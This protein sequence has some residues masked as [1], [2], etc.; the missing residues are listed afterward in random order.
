MCRVGTPIRVRRAEAEALFERAKAIPLS[1]VKELP[2][3]FG[4]NRRRETGKPIVAFGGE[5][6]DTA[7]FYTFSSYSTPASIYRYDIAT[8]A[9]SP[10]G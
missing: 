5:R 7:V 9:S 1:D 6:D 4:T 8:K 2:I 3:L 10:Q